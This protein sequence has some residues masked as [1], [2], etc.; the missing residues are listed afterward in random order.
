MIFCS[1]FFSSLLL[2]PIILSYHLNIS[3]SFLN[4]STLLH[5]RR[6]QSWEKADRN[7]SAFTPEITPLILAAHKDNYEILK[8]LLDRGAMIPMPHDI[9]WGVEGDGGGAKEVK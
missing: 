2:C 7:I 1:I 5:C 6:Q 3:S 4:F 9:R 8:I